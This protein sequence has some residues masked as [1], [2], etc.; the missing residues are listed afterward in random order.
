MLATE[1]HKRNLAY[2]HLSDQ[3]TIGAEKMPENF[4]RDFRESYRGTL[5]AAGGFTRETGE[6]ALH[7][8]DLDLIAFGRPFIANPDL[9]ER[10]KNGWPLAV[11]D[12]STWYGT[13]GE[14]GYTDFPMYEAAGGQA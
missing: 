9:V 14:H 6:A 11:A 1:L 8:G 10:M 12:R 7:S 4:A 13:A 5:I 2:V 3:F